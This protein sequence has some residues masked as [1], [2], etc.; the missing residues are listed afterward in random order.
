MAL[1]GTGLGVTYEAHDQGKEIT[2][3]WGPSVRTYPIADIEKTN[4]LA[5]LFP[6]LN[7]LSPTS[8]GLF[9]RCDLPQLSSAL[10]TLAS[11]HSDNI[12]TALLAGL[13]SAAGVQYQR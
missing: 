7:K 5:D 6:R 11:K 8:S 13:Y 12:L 9:V 3:H 2:I 1:G 4:G 10:E